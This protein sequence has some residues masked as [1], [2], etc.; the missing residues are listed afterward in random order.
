[1]KK[2]LMLIGS[3]CLALMLAVPIVAGCAAPTPTEEY[4]TKPIKIVAAFA[5][6][7]SADRNARLIEPYLE[8][9]LDV[10][11]VVEN[12]AGAGTEIGTTYV[13]R[14]PPD[15]YVI[16][17]T[18]WEYLAFSTI[19]R[20]PMYLYEDLV[21]LVIHYG[22]P[23]ILI[24]T[25]DSPFNNL[26]DIIEAAKRE[27]GKLAFSC[28]GGGGQEILERVLADR[29]N[30]DYHVLTYK[31]GSLAR[32]AVLGGQV[33]VGIGETSGAYYLRDEMKCVG[34]F[35][36]KINPL[37]PEGEPINEQL[38]PYGVEVPYFV[39]YAPLM[40]RREVKEQYPE[41]FNKLFDAFLK[42]SKDPE[43]LKKA[44]EMGI[45]PS[46]VWESPEK[47]IE[48]FEEYYKVLEEMKHL[49]EV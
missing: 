37:W 22:E 18:L 11:V 44:E 16:L 12:R 9:E 13:F 25:K 20:T 3:V 29:L 41:R 26:A 2:L 36:D 45:A 4:P 39:V 19:L 8:K 40:V 1:M 6:G 42:A 28:S 38:K 17:Q 15:G 7:G 33:D 48:T 32:A 10:P 5:A 30:L 14:E 27:P 35:D 49:M 21:S 46:L 23:R 31:G 24:V 47:Y 34:I 43:Y